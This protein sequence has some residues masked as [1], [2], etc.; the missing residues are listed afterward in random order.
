MGDDDDNQDKSG[1][2]RV[3]KVSADT[4]PAVDLFFSNKRGARR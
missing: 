3:I 2:R 1:D 4:T